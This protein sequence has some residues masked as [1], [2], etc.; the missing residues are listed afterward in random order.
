MEFETVTHMKNIIYTIPS[1][2][3]PTVVYSFYREFF[4]F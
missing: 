1:I 2:A 3:T 4:A